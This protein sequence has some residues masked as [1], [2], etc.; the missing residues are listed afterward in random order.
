MK[1]S[2]SWLLAVLVIVMLALVPFAIPSGIVTPEAQM[3]YD[4]ELSTGDGYD[5]LDDYSFL[6]DM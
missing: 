3:R 5:F 4:S 1:R 6:D 2:V